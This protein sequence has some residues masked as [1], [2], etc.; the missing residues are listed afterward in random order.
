M[1]YL[2]I[3]YIIII[4]YIFILFFVIIFHFFGVKNSTARGD[5]GPVTGKPHSHSKKSNQIQ[6]STWN[7]LTLIWTFYSIWSYFFENVSIDEMTDGTK[8]ARLRVRPHRSTQQA[9]RE[10]ITQTRR[11]LRQPA[12]SAGHVRRQRPPH[13]IRLG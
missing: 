10:R 6:R 11:L 5:K 1:C 4:I 2:F 13:R 12:A 7:S 8:A 9:E 3:F